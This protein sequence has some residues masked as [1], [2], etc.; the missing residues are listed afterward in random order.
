MLQGH[1]DLIEDGKVAGW[2]YSSIKS[3]TGM[4]LLAFSGSQCI[5]VGEIGLY[6]E[7]LQRA[8]LDDGKLGFEIRCGWRILTSACCRA[9]S[10]KNRLPSAGRPWVCIARPSWTAWTGWPRRA[11]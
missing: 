7:D 2:I 10:G 5:G 9:T 8:G 6:R 11:G 1:I 3:V 4:R